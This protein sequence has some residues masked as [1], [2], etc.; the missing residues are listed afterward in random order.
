MCTGVKIDENGNKNAKVGRWRSGDYR[1][2]ES[3]NEQ[4]QKWKDATAGMPPSD[5]RP[6]L[7][8][9]FNCHVTPLNLNKDKKKEIF[10]FCPFD[11]LHVNKV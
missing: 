2:L 11:P 6:K 5:A 1:T 10:L 8:D 7:A 9:F 3:N 4:H